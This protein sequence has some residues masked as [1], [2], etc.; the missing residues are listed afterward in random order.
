MNTDYEF[1]L[2]QF[3]DSL[4]PSGMFS[5]SNGFEPWAKFHK[6][7]N[8]NQ[9]TN[10]ILQQLRFQ[11]APL[12]CIILRDTMLAAENYDVD[13]II[14]NDM[15]YFSTKLVKE[16]RNASVRSGRQII[17]CVNKMNINSEQK[18]FLQNFEEE[19]KCNKA[20]G[21]HIIA[22]SIGMRCYS[23]PVD[24]ATRLVLYTFSTSIVSSAI[25]L[26]IIGHL[27]GQ[28]ILSEIAGEVNKLTTITKSFSINDVWQF[29]PLVEI[30][31]MNHEQDSSKMFIT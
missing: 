28:R 9:V 13:R 18:S 21:T 19:I 24:N 2:M 1:H 11:V 22:L 26:G 30:L 31:Q 27:D 4:F 10:Y 6:I 7:N 5:M 8:S 20:K 3:A 14:Q 12:D 29:A 17:N 16:V 25:R 23:I 15:F